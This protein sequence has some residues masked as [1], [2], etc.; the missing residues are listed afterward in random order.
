MQS[1]F[2]GPRHAYE[3]LKS[4]SSQILLLI[5]FELGH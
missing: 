4:Q 1:V 5:S 3:Q 2:D